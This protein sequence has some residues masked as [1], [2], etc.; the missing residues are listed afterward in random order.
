MLFVVLGMF[1][2]TV[3]ITKGRVFRLWMRHSKHV[4]FPISVGVYGPS[5]ACVG[6]SRS[7]LVF[8]GAVKYA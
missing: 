7:M 6:T 2:K 3:K 4:A 8:Q 5:D 1:A